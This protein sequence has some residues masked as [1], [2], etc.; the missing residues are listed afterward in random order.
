MPRVATFDILCKV[1]GL[2]AVYR[3][4]V[5]HISAALITIYPLSVERE[6]SSLIFANP[7]YPRDKI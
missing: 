7:K 5:F 2:F 1:F 3:E 6:F 4:I